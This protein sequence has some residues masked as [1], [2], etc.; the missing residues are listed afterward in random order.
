MSQRYSIE[1]VSDFVCPWCFIGTRRLEQVLDAKEAD[2][3]YRPFLLDPRIPIEGVD[4]R[5][6]L[7]RKFGRDPEPMFARVEGVARE[8]GIPL[9]VAKV[10]R[11]PSTLRAHALTQ[12]AKEKGT[13]R[14]LA[15]A[16]FE[17]Y[18]LQGRDIGA[19]DVLQE[20]ASAHGFDRDE[21]ARIV[22]DEAEL[23][24][25]KAEAADMA[26]EGISGVPFFVFG[27]RF[28]VSG[29]QPKEVFEKALSMISSG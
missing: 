10:R 16:L 15:N 3:T 8:T 19:T 17:N 13:Q 14:A 4:L 22:E 21:V 18:F 23:D 12:H 9:E 2:V 27:G 7:K 28:A 25:A 26:A 24:R 1:I 29:A 5:E 6:N 20:I 11:Y